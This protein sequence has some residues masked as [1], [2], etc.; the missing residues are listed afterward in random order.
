MDLN[1]FSSSTIVDAIFYGRDVNDT[2]GLELASGDVNGRG[3]G[4][5]GVGGG[6]RAGGRAGGE[7]GQPE[8]RG[9]GG[10]AGVDV[11]PGLRRSASVGGQLSG[12]FEREP[13]RHGR[14]R[15]RERLRQL[16]DDVESAP[17]APR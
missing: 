13:V 2:M 12:E 4:G 1:D 16:P 6:G 9:G 14:G 5:V 3:F 11:R 15:D 8:E 7:P 17:G 10:V